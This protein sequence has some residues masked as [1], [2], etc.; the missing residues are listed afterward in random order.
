MERPRRQYALLTKGSINVTS[1]P[2]L[3][4]VLSIIKKTGQEEAETLE[5]KS[6]ISQFKKKK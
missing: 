3:S 2:L 1:I 5:I 4:S 6:I